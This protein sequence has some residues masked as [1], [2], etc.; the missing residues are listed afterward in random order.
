MERRFTTDFSRIRVHADPDAGRAA[1]GQRADAFAFGEH[2]VFGTGRYVPDTKAGLGLI[3]HELAHVV[4]QRRS[5]SGTGA[6]V[7]LEREAEAAGR[8]SGP[9]EIAGA[10]PPAIMRKPRSRE[11]ED[12][13]GTDE[14]RGRQQDE[15][16]RSLAREQERARAGI[17]D[18]DV[19]A[20]DDERKLRALE[21]Q[22]SQPGATRRGMARKQRDLKRAATLAYNESRPEGQIP[23]ARVGRLNELMF[24]RPG[25]PAQRRHAAGGLTE[26]HGLELPPR[27]GGYAAPDIE[28]HGAAVNLKGHRYADRDIDLKKGSLDEYKTGPVRRIA[29][30]W[31]T[32]ALQNRQHLADA[33]P[34]EIRST[35]HPPKGLEKPMLDVVFYPDSPIKAVSFGT[36]KYTLA[37]HLA[38]PANA[39][40]I[41][42]A[43]SALPGIFAALDKKYARG[44]GARRA[45]ESR[46]DPAGKARRD[47]EQ[48]VKKRREA[49]LGRAEREQKR[50]ARARLAG[51]KR[52]ARAKKRAD[53]K[54][55]RDEYPKAHPVPSGP[56]ETARGGTPP[57]AKA[58]PAGKRRS[59][60][61]N[62]SAGKRTSTGSAKVSGKATGGAG[63]ASAVE[64][65]TA[66]DTRTA[67]KLTKKK[68]TAAKTSTSTG[69]AETN[70]AEVETPADALASVATKPARQ[71]ARPKR[72]GQTAPAQQ[73]QATPPPAQQH[74]AQPRAAPLGQKPPAPKPRAQKPP[75]QDTPA[76]TP[77]PLPQTQQHAVA[78]AAVTR[79]PELPELPK[80]PG[81]EPKQ[82]AAKPKPPAAK[83]KP[84]ATQPKPPTKAPQGH[85]QDEGGEHGG[86]PA[87]TTHRTGTGGAELDN[88]SA[89]IGADV[90]AGTK[91]TTHGVTLG[92]EVGAGGHWRVEVLAV[93][94]DPD[95]VAITT[96]ID[97]SEHASLS[98]GGGERVGVG[99]T[100]GVSA[101]QR[102][103]H[104][105]RF[106]GADAKKYLDAM[107]NAGAGGSLPEHLLLSTARARG[108]PAAAQLLASW[109]GR[110]DGELAKGESTERT[111]ATTASLSGNV[112]ATAGILSVSANYGKS[113]TN[114]VT[115]SIA[116]QDGENYDM[117]V[118]VNHVE[119]ETAGGGATVAKVGGSVGFEKH[120][121]AGQSYHFHVPIGD[122]SAR[123]A[124]ER[125]KSVA[126]LAALAASYPTYFRG[127]S[128]LSGSG[129]GSHV[130][131]SVL[132]VDVKMG[133]SG[134]VSQQVDYDAE[135]KKTGSQITAANEAGG[136]FGIGSFSY[137]DKVKEDFKGSVQE[138]GSATGGQL[139]VGESHHEKTTTSSIPL[140]KRNETAAE[141]NLYYTNAAYDR[142]VG[143]AHDDHDWWQHV[144]RG[145]HLADE[146]A[147]LGRRLRAASQWVKDE[148]GN[149][150]W[151][152]DATEVEAAIGAFTG[153]DTSTRL[154]RIDAIIHGT[155]GG[156]DL[157]TEGTFPGAAAGYEADFKQY[158]VVDPVANSKAVHDLD[159]AQVAAVNAGNDGDRT[160]LVELAQHGIEELTD[161][162]KH[163][164]SLHEGLKQHE[165]EFD[166][167]AVFAQMMARIGK[168]RTAVANEIA[169][170]HDVITPHP[171]VTAPPAEDVSGDKA[172]NVPVPESRPDPK[173]E[174]MEQGRAESAAKENV[175]QMWRL[176]K[177]IWSSL[178]RAEA[179]INKQDFRNTVGD[180]NVALNDAKIAID[181]W[182]ELRKANVAAIQR[183]GLNA[184]LDGPDPE[185]PHINPRYQHIYNAVHSNSLEEPHL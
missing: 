31:L 72:K 55:W 101:S 65:V 5:V 10:A 160:K 49:E 61:T 177:G 26:E 84:P 113:K 66:T 88:R 51:D 7:D 118:T 28:P 109:G 44:E 70:I 122:H 120:V 40:A 50:E 162:Q 176:N 48:N 102:F 157:G 79:T 36:T 142:V 76:Q 75:P 99:V 185:D 182:R 172:G 150:H 127:T 37:E 3:A 12:D 111:T 140:L 46:A 56:D 41:K 42:K 137:G 170:L 30:E 171:Q 125:A 161:A 33:Q 131:V 166:Q 105:R 81:T 32:Q 179:L 18:S 152:Y 115:V 67:P 39:A 117:S 151:E 135:G 147:A 146:W 169:A 59:S 143:E 92:P 155:T 145:T 167:P 27:E 4:Q 74:P 90:S 116:D 112:D 98:V 57:T 114:E 134:T 106:N 133:G 121:S 54:Y 63:A 183:Y 136:S 168:R 128:K 119:G 16:R 156:G 77:L 69:A 35:L 178:G 94:D 11:D 64:T 1:R 86:G 123:S 6:S 148:S 138:H 108:W 73:S 129:S 132:G 9:V 163:L 100:G 158:V 60:A 173:A 20:A 22:Y 23:G 68:P 93:P 21:H 130:D 149:G 141:R 34:I 104:T 24:E 53:D 14:R 107:R 52:A 154:S 62:R 13:G 25:V 89:S 15:R 184:T 45:A 82:P 38:N 124:V 8:G 95:A 181:Q 2:V 19:L 47:A 165:P 110:P 80:P 87:A 103:S 174:Q 126:D 71:T 139:A 97:M 164:D 83:P 144:N 17:D 159:N 96:T 58:Q 180:I 175:D 153:G 91:V 43:E 29:R 78:P 85:T